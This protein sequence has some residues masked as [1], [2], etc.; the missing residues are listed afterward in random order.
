MVRFVN[1][2]TEAAMS[3]LRLA[4]A[5]TGREKIIKF[6][7][8]YHGHSDGL[9]VS[10]GSGMATLGIPDSPGVPRSVAHTTLVARYN[11]I[12]S[13][14]SLFEKYP[15]SIA[16]IIVEPIAANMGVVLPG[17]GFL[18][19]LRRLTLKYGALLIFDEVITGFRVSYGGAQEIYGIKPD[20]TCLGKIIGG[21]LPVGAYGGRRDIMGMVAPAGKVYQAGTLSGNPLAMTAGV[22]MLRA[23]RRPG[24]YDS[25]EEKAAALQNGLAEAACEASLPV[26]ITRAGSIMTMF[27]TDKMVS[28]YESAMDSDTGLFSRFFLG[29]LQHGIYWPPSQFEAAFVSIAHNATDLKKT[30]NAAAAVLKTL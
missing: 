27:F 8:C 6:A 24:T 16:A 9:L 3:A 28:N 18:G 7:G 13:V 12:D 19:A 5:F 22:E 23:L 21:G 15:E 29:L 14:V 20:L 10:G 30:V 11:D 17:R 25:L 1:S 4:R 2:G 26:T